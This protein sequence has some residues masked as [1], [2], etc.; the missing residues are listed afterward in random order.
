MSIQP[1]FARVLLERPKV[2]KMGAILVPKDSQRRLATLKCKV[3]A[4]GPT[5]DSSIKP[6]MSVLIGRHAGDWISISGMP[7]V[8]EDEQF[9][10]Q[11]EDILCVVNGD[12]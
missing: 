11:D 5:A 6:G 9:I 12:G 10:V 8:A 2:E 1:L 4:V 3:L 7:G